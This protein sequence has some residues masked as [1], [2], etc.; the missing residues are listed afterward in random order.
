MEI[1]RNISLLEFY[2]ACLTLLSV[3]IILEECEFDHR[4][5]RNS[6]TFLY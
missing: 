1:K 6:Y 3:P 2:S 4:R 5:L